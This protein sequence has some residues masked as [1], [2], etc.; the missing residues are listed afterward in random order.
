M[1]HDAFTPSGQL[2]VGTTVVSA[3]PSMIGSI[4]L[5]PAAATATATVYDNATTNSGTIIANLQALTSGNS[6]VISFM[7]PVNC[8]KGITVV[9][10]GTGATCEV[11]FGRSY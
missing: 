8:L 11:T 6:A 3:A 10:A 2:S 5:T 9:V 7:Y 4:I 1:I